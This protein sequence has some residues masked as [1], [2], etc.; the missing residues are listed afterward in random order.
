M[1]NCKYSLQDTIKQYGPSNPIPE[2]VP[3][4]SVPL[5]PYCE[6]VKPIDVDYHSAV[7]TAQIIEH[8]DKTILEKLWKP[9]FIKFCRAHLSTLVAKRKP[10]FY[11]EK[12]DYEAMIDLSTRYAVKEGR[13]NT[14][15][16]HLD[17]SKN[18]KFFLIFQSDCFRY[19]GRHNHFPVA[20]G[21]SIYPGGYKLHL[22]M[23]GLFIEMDPSKWVLGRCDDSLAYVRE[24]GERNRRIPT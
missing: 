10:D 5:K 2:I 11:T 8:F 12:L 13:V 6:K 16:M 17:L 1:S 4:R 24:M 7:S 3:T 18:Q 22:E 14:L 19:Y 9:E 21:V 15:G 20:S 23:A